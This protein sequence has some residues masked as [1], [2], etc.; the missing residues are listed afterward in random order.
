MSKEYLICTV[1]Y[2]YKM[3]NCDVIKNEKKKQDL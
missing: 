2:M 3:C 1:P